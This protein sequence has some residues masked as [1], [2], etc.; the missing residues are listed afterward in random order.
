MS[1]NFELQYRFWNPIDSLEGVAFIFETGKFFFKIKSNLKNV[2]EGD[3]GRKKKKKAKFDSIFSVARAE[4]K[5]TRSLIGHRT[6]WLAQQKKRRPIPLPSG[7]KGW[8]RRRRRRCGRD[9]RW[10]VARGTLERAAATMSNRRPPV[11][12]TPPTPSRMSFSLG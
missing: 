1:L 7:A 3:M 4:K 12:E 8:R 10:P 2:S 5:R 11:R 9:G 6:V